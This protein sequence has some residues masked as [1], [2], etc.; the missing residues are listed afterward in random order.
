MPRP[1]TLFLAVLAF[2]YCRISTSF[3]LLVRLPSPVLFPLCLSVTSEATRC[4]APCHPAGPRS[5]S[6]LSCESRH[7]TSLSL[8]HLTSLAHSPAMQC[9]AH[10]LVGFPAL[11]PPLLCSASAC[12]RLV[13]PGALCRLHC[14]LP[15]AASLSSFRNLQKM[16][17]NG[18][19]PA[20]WANMK[21]LLH[22]QI[23]TARLTTT[24]P[25]TIL[26]MPNLQDL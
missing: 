26:N 7:S 18:T 13:Q 14:C 9:F 1:V 3:S 11:P 19:I 21:S 2:F 15:A 10:L 4:R 20:S 5:T 23:N 17:I 24:F 12:T 22:F 6:S 16:N 25:A 8:I